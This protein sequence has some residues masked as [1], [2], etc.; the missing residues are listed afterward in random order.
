MFSRSS[1]SGFIINKETTSDYID[2]LYNGFDYNRVAG[3]EYN[4]A[5]PD[6]RWTGKAFY[7]QSFYPGAS[8]DAATIAGNLAFSTQYF[9]A[10]LSTARIGA[11]YIAETGYIRRTGYFEMT[12]SLGYTFFPASGIVLSHGPSIVFDIIYNPDFRITDR[13]TQLGYKIGFKNRSLLTFDVSEEFV[14][15]DRP[16]DPTNTKG[17]N[18]PAGESFTWQSAGIGFA[19]DSRTLF[20]YSLDGGYG[21]YYNGTR[22]SIAGSVGYRF[23]PYGSIAV[24]ANYNNISLPDPYNSAELILIGP[25]LDITFTDKLFLT[26]FIQYNDQID[27]LNTNIR[28]QWRFAPVSDLFIVYTGNSYTADLSNKNRGLVVKLSYWFN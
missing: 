3:L 14:L 12:P 23:Q 26:T 2:T 8:G 19:S 10:S 5:S 15:L 17:E 28:F 27:N 21:S 22:W 24:A 20:T 6:N 7:H 25:K 13:Q 11:D 18:L 9:K 1:I 4:L 16:Y